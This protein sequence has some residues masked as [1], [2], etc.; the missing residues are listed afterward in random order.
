M[1]KSKN[2]VVVMRGKNNLTY[3]SD[4]SAILCAYINYENEGLGSWTQ[5]ADNLAYILYTS[6]K[7][8]KEVLDQD[9]QCALRRGIEQAS[10][11]LKEGL[12][13]QETSNPQA[14]LTAEEGV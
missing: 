12:P 11:W 1:I 2:G 4:L 14:D 6:V 10:K 7:S 3:A 8:A 5:A 13:T 9:I